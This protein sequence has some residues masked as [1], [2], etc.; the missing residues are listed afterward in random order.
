MQKGWNEWRKVC[1]ATF[2]KVSE[3]LQNVRDRDETSL[4]K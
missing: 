1:Q 2:M 3:R 4:I